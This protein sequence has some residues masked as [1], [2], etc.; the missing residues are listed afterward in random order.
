MR[1]SFLDASGTWIQPQTL[2]SSFVVAVHPDKYLTDFKSPYL[3][4]QFEDNLIWWHVPHVYKIDRGLTGAG[5]I[6]IIDGFN[7]AAGTNTL[8]PQQVEVGDRIR[9]AGQERIVKVIGGAGNTQLVMNDAWSLAAKNAK[10]VIIP[11]NPAKDRFPPFQGAG[12]ITFVSGFNAVSGDGATNFGLQVS[13]GDQ[14]TAQGET[15]VVTRVDLAT[16]KPQ[17][18]MDLAW[19][20]DGKDVTYVIVPGGIGTERLMVAYGSPI[21]TSQAPAAGAA[22]TPKDNPG[23]DNYISELN[24]F[25]KALHATL[26]LSDRAKTFP[27]PSGTG[28]LAGEVTGGYAIQLSEALQGAEARVLS[29]NWQYSGVLTPD[30]QPYKPLVDRNNGI[31]RVTLSQNSLAD[32]YWAASPPV[33]SQS[34]AGPSQGTPI[35]Y[36]IPVYASWLV[37]VS[38]QP[39]A[40]V[41]GFGAES[42]LAVSTEPGLLRLSQSSFTKSYPTSSG[43]LNEQ[44]VSAGAYTAAPVAFDKL[45]F[46]FTRLATTVVDRLS[47]R[48]L[49]LG[50][51][52]L[53]S[54]E[55]QY[56]PELPFTRFYNKTNNTPGPALDTDHLPPDLMEFNGAYGLYF[57]EV[58]FYNAFLIADRLNGNQRFDEA[59]AWYEKIF[60]PTQPLNS[61]QIRRRPLLAL[62]SVPRHHTAEPDRNPHRHGSDRGLPER[63][64]R[65]A[66][67]CAVAPRRLSEGDRDALCRQ[68]GR[69]GRLAV[70]PG[71]PRDHHPGHRALHPRQRPV[72]AA[73]DPGR[74]L[75]GPGAEELRRD[76]GR[77]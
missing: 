33:Q 31:L 47:R 48:L 60:N 34:F 59:K 8:F 29:M 18:V 37:P 6:T 56:L 14:I 25:N 50:T 40:F 28:T 17:L 35:L 45:K 72:G 3:D 41:F 13:V 2:V 53:L 4:G 62:P 5:R 51:D 39:G 66:R 26:V 20:V 64:V 54:L 63:P 21:D 55:S 46:R 7:V 42:Y 24:Q 58:F 77:I 9:C 65:S 67:H 43:N 75:P 22:P 36:N 1:Y 76:Q 19:G 15:R 38:N 44:L 23:R 27:P 73:S 74:Q 69:L 71:Y 32:D 57:W 30:L 12:T 61:D 16:Q 49:A 70:C 11:K 10:Y 68:P 52:G